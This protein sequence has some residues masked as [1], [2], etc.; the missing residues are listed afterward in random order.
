MGQ[1]EDLVW[2]VYR[3]RAWVATDMALLLILRNRCRARSYQLSNILFLKPTADS[4]K[5]VSR[6]L[7]RHQPGKILLVP[8]WYKN[9]FTVLSYNPPNAPPLLFDPHHGGT[10][11][12]ERCGEPTATTPLTV[13][14]GA[15]SSDCCPVFSVYPSPTDHCSTI[16]STPS[17]PCG[18]RG[19]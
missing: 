18:A 10:D 1:Y 7:E 15:H 8:M 5:Q 19:T 9:H 12:A 4:L 3:C 13:P 17:A 2:A 14:T 6:A 16:P 11:H